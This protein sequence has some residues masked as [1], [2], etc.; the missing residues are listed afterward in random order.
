MMCS[1]SRQFFI[2]HLIL[3]WW[4]WY[5]L[6]YHVKALCCSNSE[7]QCSSESSEPFPDDLLIPL[8]HAS[9]LFPSALAYSPRLSLRH[10]LW[11]ISAHQSLNSI[12]VHA[13]SRCASILSAQTVWLSLLYYFLVLLH[14]F[15]LSSPKSYYNLNSA[16]IRCCPSTYYYSM[17]IF[18]S[19][20]DIARSKNRWRRVRCRDKDINNVLYLVTGAMHRALLW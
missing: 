6:H 19:D 17:S 12:F 2:L 16:S 18:S 11:I 9:E 7:Y 14:S 3:H 13:P 1:E 5:V 20:I 4:I 8:P 10:W 15:N